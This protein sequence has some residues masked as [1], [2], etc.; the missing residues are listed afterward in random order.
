MVILAIQS[1]QVVAPEVSSLSGL[2]I[3]VGRGKVQGETFKM[4]L[5]LLLFQFVDRGCD[6]S[7]TETTAMTTS[8]TDL[9]RDPVLLCNFRIYVV[10]CLFLLLVHDTEVIGVLLQT[11]LI[12]LCLRT[13][14]MG[15]ELSENYYS[16]RL[17]VRRTAV[18]L[19][20]Q[21]ISAPQ[22]TF[23]FLRVTNV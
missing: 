2:F 8:E 21:L 11:E 12:P 4:D 1:T 23:I 7:K 13:M 6:S 22:D 17:K 19:D 15:S 9:L 18:F 5:M 10:M 14:E 3:K 20:L 16:L